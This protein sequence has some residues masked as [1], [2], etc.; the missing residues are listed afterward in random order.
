[1]DE[2]EMLEELRPTVE[3]LHD[4]ELE[5]IWAA[6][7]PASPSDVDEESSGAPIERTGRTRSTRRR[8]ILA[9]TAAAVVLVAGTGAYMGAR[10]QMT[11]ASS[12]A[13]TASVGVDAPETNADATDRQAHSFDGGQMNGYVRSSAASCAVGATDQ[14][15]Q[16]RAFAL[17]GTVQS[18]SILDDGRVRSIYSV[19]RWFRGGDG[20]VA[21]VITDGPSPEEDMPRPVVGQ[22]QLVAGEL[23]ESSTPKDLIGWGC[24][25][26]REWSDADEILWQGAFQ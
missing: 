20:E 8:W 5:S 18:V 16:Q 14:Q 26:T 15:L 12:E 22:R 21:V 4:A 24:G 11:G 25:F 23:D 6:I 3:P 13:G 1:M 9:G 10:T 7:T 2:I 19:D 17:S